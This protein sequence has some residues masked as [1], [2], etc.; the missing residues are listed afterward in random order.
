MAGGGHKYGVNVQQLKEL[1]ETK[2]EEAIGRIKTQFRDVQG[3]C[4]ALR[5][6]TNE[7]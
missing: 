4:N 5:T 3:L 6:S 7:G 2:S 1:M